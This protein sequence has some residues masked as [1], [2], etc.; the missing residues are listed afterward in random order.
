MKTC[1]LF[2]LCA[3]T[4]PLAGQQT[5]VPDSLPQRLVRTR[6]GNEFIG[7]VVQETKDTLTLQTTAY[8]VVSIPSD[9]IRRSRAITPNA[10]RRGVYWF[11]SPMDTRYFL[12]SNAFGLRKGEG[13]Y[14]NVWVSVNQIEVGINDYFS[15]GVG[16]IPAFILGG[17]L[18][19]WTTPKVSIPVVKDRLHIGG[20]GF[21]GSLLSPWSFGRTSFGY[22]YGQLTWGKRDANITFGGGY[23]YAEGDWSSGPVF[24]ISGMTR[25]SKKVALISENYFTRA[26][27]DR[28]QV[29]SGG[30]RI[31]GKKIS[32]DAAWALP[33]FDFGLIA[34]PWISIAAPLGG[35]Y[36]GRKKRGARTK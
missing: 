26:Q 2:L 33:V 18:P 4:L 29:I 20:G 16:S 22:L 34:V 14:Q 36:G 28:L 24:S 25:L 6:D 27:G 13:Y 11:D 3:L 10:A 17:A 21:L 7:T 35:E 32:F 15:M 31:I 23:A 30:L 12:G 8:G 9:Q 5:G 19:I 1:F